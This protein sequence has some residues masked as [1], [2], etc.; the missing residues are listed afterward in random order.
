LNLALSLSGTYAETGHVELKRYVAVDEE[1]SL[2]RAA[3]RGRIVRLRDT[4]GDGK[5]DISTVFAKVNASPVHGSLVKGT[6]YS[7]GLGTHAEH[8]FLRS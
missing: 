8:F 7:I 4:D 6:V 2:G 3:G 1:G 5:A